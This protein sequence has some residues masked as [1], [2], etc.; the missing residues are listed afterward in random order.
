M[1]IQVLIPYEMLV[2]RLDEVIT[3]TLHPEIHFS[4]ATLDCCDAGEVRRVTE[5]LRSNGI[6]YS[7]H[8]PYMDLTP[9]A[10]DNKIRKATQER[11]EET[12]HLAAVAEARALVCHPGYDEWRHGDFKD[13]WLRGSVQMW[14]PLVEEAEKQ[15]I[16]KN[17]YWV[18]KRC[19]KSYKCPHK[20]PFYSHE[21]V[22][23]MLEADIRS[24]RLTLS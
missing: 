14:T 13:L 20:S 1:I 23:K 4:G 11:L 2:Q 10:V 7:F 17:Y 12:L 3:K 19:G 8:A 22:E 9:G 6:T 16:M 21:V 18:C 5:A 24:G 15:G